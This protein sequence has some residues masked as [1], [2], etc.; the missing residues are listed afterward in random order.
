MYNRNESFDFSTISMSNDGKFAR[1]CK[2]RHRTHAHSLWVYILKIC[3]F[4]SLI[5]FGR[6]SMAHRVFVVVRAH[7][8]QNVLSATN[9]VFVNCG[10]WKWNRSVSCLSTFAAFRTF[11]WGENTVLQLHT[12]CV[13]FLSL[14]RRLRILCDFCLWWT[15][16]DVCHIQQDERKPYRQLAN[17]QP[18]PTATSWSLFSATQRFYTVSKWLSIIYISKA[19]N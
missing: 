8:T 3:V 11:Q 10:E 18:T 16:D 5:W 19:C 7:S 9:H 6:K 15:P 17:T 1:V 14:I 13:F 4:I 12:V 2:M